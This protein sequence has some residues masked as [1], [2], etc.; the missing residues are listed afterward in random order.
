M[1]SFWRTDISKWLPL[2]SSFIANETL[3]NLIYNLQVWKNVSLGIWSPF[4]Y[5]NKWFFSYFEWNW[6]LVCHNLKYPK[7][8]IPSEMA[9][10][11]FIVTSSMHRSLGRQRPA[12]YVQSLELH[13]EFPWNE[14][15][16]SAVWWHARLLI[17][18]VRTQSHATVGFSL[19]LFACCMQKW[20][21]FA[22][23]IGLIKFGDI[24]LSLLQAFCTLYEDGDPVAK[25]RAPFLFQD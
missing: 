21:S 14:R 23:E 19:R 3:W 16:E 15:H 2:T 10:T 4:W 12:Q 22:K 20:Q 8:I 9:K 18:R 17:E 5:W 6:F 1:R 11:L 7:E 25:P 13:C 24:S